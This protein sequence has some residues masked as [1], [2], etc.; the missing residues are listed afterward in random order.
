MFRL[1]RA[2]AFQSQLIDA[3]RTELYRSQQLIDG[4]ERRI[5][6]MRMP[7]DAPR[8]AEA[9]VVPR[10]PVVQDAPNQTAPLP[11]PI[12]ARVEAVTPPI[13]GYANSVVTEHPPVDGPPI[14]EGPA[15]VAFGQGASSVA[16][17][18]V[19]A[20]RAQS[21]E[22]RVGVNWLNRIGIT[23]LVF[24]VAFF[25]AY[26][27]THMGPLGKVLSGLL[28]AAAVLGGGFWLERKPQYAVFARAAI[29]GGW[30]L[31]FFTVFAMHFVDATLVLRS[32]LA[33]L[34]LLFFVG[35]GMVL[36]SL[37]YRSQ[38]V[39]GLAFLLAFS[40]VTISHQTLYS[41]LGSS[42][43]AL[44]LEFV[45]AREG[46]YL[47]ELAGIAAAYGN[48]FLWLSRTLH[49][50][51]GPG[52]PFA[53]FWPSTA[54]LLLF[55]LIF[56]IGYVV[57]RPKDEQAEALSSAG[58]VLNAAIVLMVMRYQSFHPAWAF[59][60]LLLFGA[61]EF[62]F[63]FVVRGRGRRAAFAV[64]ATLGSVLVLAAV[65]FRYG[66]ATWALLWV[67]EGEAL[68]L[69]GLFTRERVLRFVGWVAIATA[70]LKMFALDIG[71]GM[72]TVSS[73]SAI[74]DRWLVAAAFAVAAIALWGNSEWL[75]GKLDDALLELEAIVIHGGSGLA[76]AAFATALWVCTGDWTTAMLWSA[77][78]AS[79]FVA[80]A[81]SKRLRLRLEGY[82]VMALAVLRVLLVD[83]EDAKTMWL[84]VDRRMVTAVVV[85]AACLFV[86]ERLRVL[87]EDAGS[88]LVLSEGAWVGGGAASAMG[89]V[90]SSLLYLELPTQW[91]AAGW[92]GL[93][94]L[95]VAGAFR[96][97]GV[98]P[99]VQ[100]MLLAVMVVAR[101]GVINL[102]SETWR[103][104]PAYVAL[105]LLFAA[106]PLAFRLRKRMLSSSMG[107]TLL[108]RQPEQVLFFAPLVGVL[109]LLLEEF[110]GG[111]LTLSV[112]AL[113]VLVFVV[114]LG[115]E[116][117]SYRLAGLGL[118]L[119]GVAKLLLWDVWQMQPAERYVSLIGVGVALLLVSFLYSRF[120]DRLKRYL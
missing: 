27:V 98:R 66:G 99:R 76:A 68:W 53:E 59:R 43:L 9:V 17:P 115:V 72:A 13:A 95:Q 90:L 78:G 16:E 91:L 41:L 70:V 28:V 102:E 88:G 108:V 35:V 34:F 93:A 36:H 54:V 30:A 22:H 48:H 83:F 47:L 1:S 120:A 105:A 119:A 50:E 2:Q 117:R 32:E 18:G 51:M 23:L 86:S 49:E 92:A 85:M 107:R 69:A 31:I 96:R 4:L 46:W 79:L 61:L 29:G 21:F 77:A 20:G 42:V 101:L 81:M 82:G 84:S 58:A 57:R 8:P 89:V 74:R 15:S 65:P 45:C 56:R 80:G 106:L 3:L 113:G 112:S 38:V 97:D 25:L 116:E 39:T 87:N 62:C 100:A 64:L 114:A 52:Q 75:S 37:R 103:R 118:L 44:G 111:R 6:A 5:A 33:D 94:L 40:T 26:Q 63:A 24:G 11:A 104:W 60:A 10:A 109:L 12:A 67:A 55:F 7:S 110:A 19:A 71:I 14:D 73:V